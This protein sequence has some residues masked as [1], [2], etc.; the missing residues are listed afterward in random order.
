MRWMVLA[1]VACGGAGKP[2][3][4]P[5]TAASTTGT[6]TGTA[7]GT[8]TGTSTGGTTPSPAGDEVAV[9]AL[10]AGDADL[11][12]VM[13]VVAWSGGW[14]VHTAADTWLFVAPG[15]GSWSIAGDHDA[16][17]GRPMVAA[18]GFSW[19]ELEV[20][21]PE[22]SGYKLDHGR[23]LGPDAWAR[24]YVWDAY[25]ELSFVR[26]PT[27]RARLDRWPGLEA[28]GLLPRDLTLYV[29]P[30][31]GPWPVLYAHDG[32][33]LFDPGAIWGGWRLDEALATRTDVLVV[34]IANTAARMDEYT[35]TQDEALGYVFGGLGADYARL[36]G[37]HVR[38]HVEATYGSTGLDGLLGSSLGGLI[39]LYIA[40]QQPGDWDFAASMS[41]TLGWGRM[42]HSNPVMDELWSDNVTPG[43]LVVYVD[44]GG[45]AGP[46]GGCFDL[47]GD[48]YPEDDPD[49]SD[50]YCETRDFADRRAA[51]GWTWGVNLHH[52]H[53][54]GATHDELA[55]AERVGR[56]LDLFLGLD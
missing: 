33:N 54:V 13:Q 19:I 12:V 42:V 29:P 31:D 7:T 53:E 11:D 46:D 1:L 38:P 21:A 5:S 24:S 14:P 8:P 37:D 4:D 3:G 26:P 15:L 22:G 16:W 50:N 27:D 56:P 32:Q 20:P 55:W 40:E 51:E 2:G 28:E 48:G 9:R 52:W 35:H 30:G 39:S 44:S 34:G 36:I 18:E 41:G 47:D 10:I 25:G 49:S 17:A 45:D 43:S 6:T 23:G